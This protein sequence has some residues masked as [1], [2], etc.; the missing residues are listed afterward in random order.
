MSRSYDYRKRNSLSRRRRGLFSRLIP[1]LAALC[2]LAFLWLFP[3]DKMSDFLTENLASD[4]QSSPDSAADV[5]DKGNTLGDGEANNGSADEK[6][7]DIAS[8]STLAEESDSSLPDGIDN[9]SRVFLINS[10]DKDR[11]DKRVISEAVG[12]DSGESLAADYN[13]ANYNDVWV[14]DAQ[15]GE[16]GS[17]SDCVVDNSI[18]LFR[19]TAD[20]YNP[21]SGYIFQAAGQGDSPQLTIVA[22][23]DKN[24]YV[25]LKDCKTGE[26]SL[27]FYVRAGDTVQA[28]IPAVRCEFY[29]VLGDT[30]YGTEH[31]FGDE[32]I[33]A[34]SDKPLDFTVPSRRYKYTFDVDDANIMPIPINEAE[35][36][37]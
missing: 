33:Y 28:C 29:Y 2:V 7:L 19:H 22:P 34:K 6:D 27:S 25:K 15:I 18:R 35:F 21:P 32:G 12:G 11:D 26:T 5:S 37:A 36:V 13:S 1:L 17:F 14:S 3:F 20:K 31:L 8:G 30:W 10:A 24:A 23:V 4:S 9:G 16:S